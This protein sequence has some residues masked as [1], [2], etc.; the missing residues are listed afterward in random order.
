MRKIPNVFVRDFDGD[1]RRVT[2]AVEPVSAWALAGEGV[3]TRKWDGTAVLWRD[4]RLWRRYDAKRG[5]KPPADFV[6]AQEPDEKTGHHPGWIPVGNGPEDAWIVEASMNDESAN[7]VDGQTY[8]ACGPKI[9]GNPE[10]LPQ[11]ILIRH[12]GVEI[13]ARL[14]DY[15]SVREFLM[16]GGPMEGIVWHHPDGRMAKVKRR[17]FGLPWGHGD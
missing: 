15:D 14:A 7:M 12:G 10:N 1:P 6:P 16:L 9:N 8:E 11:H 17:D 4:G 13:K 5:K 2:P 3:A